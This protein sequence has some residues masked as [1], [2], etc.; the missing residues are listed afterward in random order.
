MAKSTL[1]QLEEAT[2]QN[3]ALLADLARTPGKPVG[4]GLQKALGEA[5]AIVRDAHIKSTV[6]HEPYRIFWSNPNEPSHSRLLAHF[7]DPSYEHGRL[8]LGSF[9]QHLG[10]KVDV[11]KSLGSVKVICEKGCGEGR[12]VDLAV[13]CTA[14]NCKWAVVIENKVNG[15]EDQKG[16][17]GDYV[18]HIRKT[19][20]YG[21]KDDQVRP[22]YL[23]L[24]H[25]Q[26]PPSQQILGS[27][28]QRGDVKPASFERNIREWIKGVGVISP[29]IDDSLRHYGRL[30]DYLVESDKESHMQRSVVQQLMKSGAANQLAGSWNEISAL[31]K[32][33][34]QLREYCRAR[35]G[36]DLLLKTRDLLNS[37]EA[38]LFSARNSDAE[39]EEIEA[40]HLLEELIVRSMEGSCFVSLPVK[41]TDGL[42]VAAAWYATDEDEDE[43]GIIIEY[44]V[45]HMT[46][47]RL[48][49]RVKT[50]RT[51]LR[52]PTVPVHG[53]SG[54]P[55]YQWKY[56]ERVTSSNID[57]LAAALAAELKS[58][59]EEASA[60][61]AYGTVASARRSTAD[62]R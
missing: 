51:E 35:L 53:A 57:R 42:V 15:A 3:V 2:Q 48:E 32:S 18:K 9:L 26:E 58:L 6:A 55:W 22:V 10:V 41:G 36:A 23:T 62:H 19:H 29:E 50:L 37:G 61:K 27:G 30:I 4:L 5:V 44:G 60:T 54:T 33:A 52:A 21:K 43:E 25:R 8:L 49:S 1:S 38:G 28:V 39:M 14:R 47:T 59:R 24:R 31:V 34:K 56:G 12:R 13:V 46:E 45:R 11:E 20:K 40:D 7:I 16:Q 17:L